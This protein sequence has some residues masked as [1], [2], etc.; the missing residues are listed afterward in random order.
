[1]FWML[2]LFVV[3]AFV[4]FKL[5]AY[6]VVLGLFEV[7]AKVLAVATGA[8]LVVSASRWAMRRWRGRT[9]LVWR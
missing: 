3:M 1:M 4:F 5:G 9:V 8:L 7:L 6:S 2:V